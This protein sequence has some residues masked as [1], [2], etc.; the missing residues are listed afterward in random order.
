MPTE[1]CD[2]GDIIGSNKCNA[3]CTGPA[4]GW[5]CSGGTTTTPSTCVEVC[6]DGVITASEA[7]DDLNLGPGDGC[8]ATC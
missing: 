8:S 1:N 4:P 3:L 5:T 7:C 2:D 6:G